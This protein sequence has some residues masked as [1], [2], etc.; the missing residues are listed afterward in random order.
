MEMFSTAMAFALVM[1]LLSTVVSGIVE[2]ISRTTRMRA[3][4]LHQAITALV[5][6]VIWP[7]LGESVEQRVK[8]KGTQPIT[9]GV[10]DENATAGQLADDARERLI[11]SKVSELVRNPV[12]AIKHKSH[13]GIVREIGD[14]LE[15][16]GVFAVLRGLKVAVG[17]GNSPG[18]DELS[19]TAFVQRLAKTEIGTV[20]ADSGEADK[21]L[22]VKDFSNSFERYT[23]A[24]REIYR[25]RLHYI[26]VFVAIFLAFGA[27]IDASRL[28]RALSEDPEFRNKILESSEEITKLVDDNANSGGNA[29]GDADIKKD[30]AE[31]RKKLS[32]IK[33]TYDLPIGHQYFPY[34]VGDSK[35]STKN[36]GPEKPG[37]YSLEG[38][39]WIVNALFAGILIG[40][41]GPFWFKVF[42]SLSQLT[43]LLGVF[44]GRN[45]ELVA[46]TKSTPE[47]G[48]TAAGDDTILLDLFN[49]AG[50]VDPDAKVVKTGDTPE[51]AG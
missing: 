50:G 7:K 8:G 26:S 39:N 35:N 34:C 45:K 32:D 48:S 49:V 29:Q 43:Q 40:L 1:I 5:K 33:S 19:T 3:G 41:G 42:S 13:T 46:E 44:G 12:V 6:D 9:T 2:I 10:D 37:L 14:F 31:I 27:N 21:T 51:P 24:S 11:E 23:A 25:K 38:L 28:F 18:V 47:S 20:M 17:F 30:V 16:I 15:N 22:M 36:C 4:V